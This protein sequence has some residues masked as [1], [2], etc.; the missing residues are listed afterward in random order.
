MNKNTQA[1]ARTRF[2]IPHFDEIKTDEQIFGD[3]SLCKALT[4]SR[5]T[6]KRWCDAQIIPY[7]QKRSYR[8]YNLAAVIK[9]LLQAGYSQENPPDRVLSG[10]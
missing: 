9:A 8:E 4:V 6:I 3:T 5:F 2:V 10:N 1:M 7:K